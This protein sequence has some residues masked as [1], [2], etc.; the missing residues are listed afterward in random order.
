[1]FLGNVGENKK[2]ALIFNYIRV[3]NIEWKY[4][5]QFPYKPGKAIT[6]SN[7]VPPKVLSRIT[8]LSVDP[9]DYYFIYYQKADNI[10]IHCIAAKQS[11]ENSHVT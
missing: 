8:I 5:T 2:N 1:M 6:T 4:S 7:T 11:S 10:N 9:N 3:R